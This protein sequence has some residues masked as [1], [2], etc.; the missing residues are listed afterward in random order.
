M[1]KFEKN[2]IF[3]LWVTRIPVQQNTRFTKQ[4]FYSPQL[5]GSLP[6]YILYVLS[7]SSIGEF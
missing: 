1:F 6:I 7:R 3:G 2:Q 5:V 4:M